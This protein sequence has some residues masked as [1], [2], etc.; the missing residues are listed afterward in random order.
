MKR[1]GSLK[2]FT[3]N[4]QWNISIST[5]VPIDFEIQFSRFETGLQVLYPQFT[6]KN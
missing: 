2:S 6:G 4:F 5:L 3:W 1:E